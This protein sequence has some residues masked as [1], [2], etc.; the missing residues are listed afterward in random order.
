[1][2]RNDRAQAVRRAAPPLHQV[3][4]QRVRI[5]VAGLRVD[6]DQS[7]PGAGLTDRGRGRDERHRRRDHFGA[8]PHSDREQRQA[9]RI[10][11]VADADDVANAEVGC[12]LLF[13]GLDLRA[14]RYSRH[15]DGSAPVRVPRA[16]GFPRVC[17]TRSTNLICIGSSVVGVDCLAAGSRAAHAGRIAGHHRAW[18][19]VTRHHR[20]GADHRAAR[21][22]STPHRIDRA[23]S[24]RGAA[25]HH[26]GLHPPVGSRFAARRP[27][28]SRGDSGR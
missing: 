14:A 2:H 15:R 24:D 25:P 10:G 20:A 5:D 28:W 6:V 26:R 11:A 21:R 22:W 12:E 16:R 19:H 13:E 4:A 8:R 3:A 17:E 1:M 27:P 7:R 9:D 23:A 18:R